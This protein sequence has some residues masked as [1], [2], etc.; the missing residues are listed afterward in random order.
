MRTNVLGV[1]INA[2]PELR[3]AINEKIEDMWEQ[4]IITED[5][6]E[7]CNERLANRIAW[8]QNERTNTKNYRF[9][10]VWVAK[11]YEHKFVGSHRFGPGDSKK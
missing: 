6:I 5:N 2:I 1:L 11:R 3:N 9:R 10:N 8:K 7:R 4:I